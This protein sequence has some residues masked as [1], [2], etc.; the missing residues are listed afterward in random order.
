MCMCC[1]EL[2]FLCVQY[3]YLDLD[4]VL[5][6]RH[7]ISFLHKYVH[8]VMF[9]VQMSLCWAKPHSSK[10]LRGGVKEGSVDTAWTGKM[11]QN[12]LPVCPLSNFRSHR[13]VQNPFGYYTNLLFYLILY[14]T[15][16]KMPVLTHVYVTKYIHHLLSVLYTYILSLLLFLS[17]FVFCMLFIAGQ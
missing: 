3:M 16:Y 9:I 12:R 7:V 13:F 11:G 8:L 6:D 15:L 14:L 4:I 2:L 1:L 17:W 10:F 5:N